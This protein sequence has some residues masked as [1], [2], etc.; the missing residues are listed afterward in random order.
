MAASVSGRFREGSRLAALGAAAGVIVAAGVSRLLAAQLYGVSPNDPVS[1]AAPIAAIG[2][3]ALA[4]SWLPARR[5]MSVTP[6]DA[7]RAQ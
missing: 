2:I 6:L 5:A 7:L 3:A 4:A 1:Y